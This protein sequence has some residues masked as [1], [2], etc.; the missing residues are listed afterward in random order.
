MRYI[1]SLVIAISIINFHIL[2]IFQDQSF[3]DRQFI[4]LGSYERQ[5]NVMYEA[6]SLMEYRWNTDKLLL[7]DV[8]TQAEKE[9]L[10]DVKKLIHS[11]EY[12]FLL[13]VL[14]VIIWFRYLFD[15]RFFATFKITVLWLFLLFVAVFGVWW[16]AWDWLFVHFHELF[17]AGNWMFSSDSFLIQSYPWEFF[18]NA[19]VIVLVRSVIGLAFVLW[20]LFLINKKPRRA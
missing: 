19:M 2:Y 16:F 1:Y 17:F 8:Y 12:V 3:F 11:L 15:P 6:K 10:Y 13:S 4:Q 9:H 7:S 5:E 14:F 20:L 18:R